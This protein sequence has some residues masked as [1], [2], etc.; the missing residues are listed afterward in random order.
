MESE[1]QVSTRQRQIAQN[2][3]IHPEVSFTSLAHHIDLRWLHEAFQRTRKD[4]AV[5]VDGQ[6]AEEYAKNLGGNLRDLL[7]RA[8]AGT[9]FAPPVRRVYIPKG[10]GPESRPIGIPSFEDKVLQRA[11]QMVLEP[12]YEQDFLDCSYGFRPGR[13]AHDALEA[14]WKGLMT[15]GGGWMI[16]L[17]IRKFFDTLDFK[18]LR[19]ILNKRVCDGVLLRLIGKWLNAGVL[20]EGELSY[21]RQGTPQGGVISPTLSNIYLHEVLDKWFDSVVKPRL[22]GRA[23]EI[24][25]ADDAVLVFESK[26]DAQRVMEVLPK[27]FGRYNLTVHPE[28][29]RLIYFGKPAEREQETPKH[30]RWQKFDFMGFTHYWGRSRKGRWVIMR[31]T[32]G[33]R[34]TRALRNVADW[35]RRNR[36]APL[37]EQQRALTRKLQGH[38]AYYGITGNARC[39][40]SFFY[41]VQRAWHK[42]LS[43]RSRGQPMV[44]ERFNRIL[45]RYPLPTPRIVHSCYA[46]NL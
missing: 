32:Q 1:E 4:A 11:V 34:F 43:R 45:Q 19:E 39:L 13:S 40:N 10:T 31:R 25:Y 22:K 33:T 16:D 18:C 29:T 17:D 36:H 46:A 44:W 35:C 26:E 21:P 42:W 37:G 6:T 41:E 12:L 20:E 28:K 23:F 38:Y 2:A 30:P 7:E 9:Y 3:R 5:G 27:R 24:R 8:K 15:M 14:L